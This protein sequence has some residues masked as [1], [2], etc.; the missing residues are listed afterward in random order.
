MV[1]RDCNGGGGMILQGSENILYETLRWIYVIYLY[2][3]ISHISQFLECKTPRMN[4][5]VIMICLC[6]C[7]SC[8][9]YTTLVEDVDS[10]GGYARAGADREYMGTLSSL[11]FCCEPLTALIGYNKVLILKHPILMKIESLTFYLQR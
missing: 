6:K 1:S 9:K 5:K 2:I 7:V 3:C 11:Q 4:P 8:S 10:R